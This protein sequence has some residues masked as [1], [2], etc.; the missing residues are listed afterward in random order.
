MENGQLPAFATT[1]L[2]TDEVNYEPQLGLT[3]RE[4]FAAMAMQGM[5]SQQNPNSIWEVS[6]I[7][8][9]SIKHADAVLAGLMD[10]RTAR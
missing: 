7:V 5:L 10:D 9:N 3:K 4:Y 6:D 8:E 2:Y 1:G